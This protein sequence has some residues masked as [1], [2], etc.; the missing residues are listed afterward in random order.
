MKIPFIR[1]S[2][3]ILCSAALTCSGAARCLAA[4]ESTDHRIEP[5]EVIVIEVFQEKDLSKEVKVSAEGEITMPLLGNMKVGGRTTSEVKVD[6]EQKLGA[7]YLVSPQVTVTVREYRKRTV[8]VLGQVFKPGPVEL[9]G[10]QKIDLLEAI[11]YAQGTT[12]LANTKR[13]ELTR[14]G[15]TEKFNLEDLRKNTDPSKKFWLEP[16]DVIFVPESV[17]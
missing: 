14:K 4:D 6:L 5:L 8:T 7:D 1:R 15:K 2:L 10:E 13:V 16:G 17:L 11:G 3:L 9:T 12:R